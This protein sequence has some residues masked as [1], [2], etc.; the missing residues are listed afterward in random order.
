[1]N[2]L[3]SH[4]LV[5]AVSAAALMASSSS[6][7]DPVHQA[8]VDALGPEAPGIPQGEYH[9][10]GQPCTVCHGPE[11]PANTQFALAGTVF[12]GPDCRVGA[13]NTEIL[14]VD[15]LGNRPQGQV[16]SNCV[17]NFFIRQE[18]FPQLAFPFLGWIRQG[19]QL[20]KMTSH[21]SRESSCNQCHKDPD[22]DDAPGH[23]YLFDIEPTT[24]EA[25]SCPVDPGVPTT[26]CTDPRAAATG[27]SSKTSSTRPL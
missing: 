25:V 14:I 20:K 9:R 17:G 12:T 1:M 10:A 27:S 6:C 18:L 16:V 15:S 2:R 5:C 21:V 24:Y 8:E 26:G 3:L 7:T 11:G 19:N 23:M 4:V 22:S 13:P